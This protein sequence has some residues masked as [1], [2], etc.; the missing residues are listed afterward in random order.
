M[1]S[2]GSLEQTRQEGWG[3]SDM[4]QQIGNVE[5][6]IVLGALDQMAPPPSDAPSVLVVPD[7]RHAVP[8]EQG[9]CGETM[10]WTFWTERVTHNVHDERQEQCT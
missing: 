2:V 4:A 10:S 6:Q 7:C 3:V 1:W 5:C 9:G 8:N